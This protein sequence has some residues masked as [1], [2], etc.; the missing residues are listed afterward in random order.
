[1]DCVFQGTQKAVRP[2]RWFI[3]LLQH[4]HVAYVIRVNEFRY[5]YARGRVRGRDVYG[6]NLPILRGFVEEHY[7]SVFQHAGY[8][9]LE[10][11]RSTPTS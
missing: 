11:R 3:D 7:T 2:G 10:L 6:L 5:G 9:V 1:M 8:E 4:H